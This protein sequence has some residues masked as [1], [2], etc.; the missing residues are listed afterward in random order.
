MIETRKVATSAEVYAVLKAAHHKELVPFGS[1]SAPEGKHGTYACEMYTEWGFRAASAPLMA[2]RET[3]H[4][5]Q[6][7]S[8]EYRYWLFMAIDIDE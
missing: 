1:F 6:D 7:D 8:R 4:K 5:G 2:V 3:W